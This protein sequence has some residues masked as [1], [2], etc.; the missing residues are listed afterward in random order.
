MAKGLKFIIA[1][2]I[3]IPV[4]VALLIF[5]P[6]GGSAGKWVYFLPDLNATIN[7]IT[8]LLLILGLYFIKNNQQF[9]HKRVM[10][11]AFCLGTIFLISY[12]TYHSSTDSTVYGDINGNGELENSEAAKI[13][14]MRTVYLIVLL[15]HIL[16]A[17]A[18]VPLVLLAMY[19]ALAKKFDKHKKIVKWAFPV[20]LYVSVTGVIVYL[21]IS[22]YYQH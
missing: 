5:I 14:G 2:S 13:A 7:S 8:A 12:I 10:V 18:V 16:L 6:S 20:W 17:I 22:P 21:M 19:F 11:T 15:S 3:I 9:N 4:V 1:I